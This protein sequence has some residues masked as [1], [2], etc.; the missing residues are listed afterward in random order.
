LRPTR[1][2]S[3]RAPRA[4]AW[5]SYGGAPGDTCVDGTEALFHA[6][7]SALATLRPASLL[8]LWRRRK[9][10]KKKKKKKRRGPDQVG[11]GQRVCARNGQAMDAPS[12]DT[13][14]VWEPARGERRLCKM[15]SR[16]SGRVFCWA[17]CGRSQSGGEPGRRSGSGGSRLASSTLFTP[18]WL[19]LH[20]VTQQPVATPTGHLRC[21]SRST[22][23]KPTTYLTD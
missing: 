14:T 4:C 9:K 12:F 22:S 5:T 17:R 15:A 11:S 3:N 8:R 6:I 16:G 13:W 7:P 19:L 18:S 20:S 10:Q 1:G 23:T 21:N 2:L